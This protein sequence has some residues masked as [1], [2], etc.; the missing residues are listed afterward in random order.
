MGSTRVKRMI[1]FRRPTQKLASLWFPWHKAGG[2]VAE[3]KDCEKLYLNVLLSE[4]SF[5][6][7]SDFMIFEA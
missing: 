3:N 6:N 4:T 1:C 2:I 5:T 7:V